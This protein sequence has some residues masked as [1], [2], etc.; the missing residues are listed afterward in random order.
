MKASVGDRIDI[1]RHDEHG[2]FRDGKI[3]E[4]PDPRGEPP[5]YVRWSDNGH[6]SLFFP[7]P[8]ARVRHYEESAAPG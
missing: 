5:Y 2:V 3:I 4:V 8:D 6:V 1:L 7:G